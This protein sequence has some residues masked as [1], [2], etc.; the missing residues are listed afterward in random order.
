[1]SNQY[2]AGQQQAVAFCFVQICQGFERVA[3]GDGKADGFG[4]AQGG[5]V[6]ERADVFGD[7]FAE[8]AHIGAF[9]ATHADHGFGCVKFGNI[10]GVT[11]IS[12]GLRSMTMPLRAYSYSGLPSCMSAENIGGTWRM[13]PISAW[14]AV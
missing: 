13:L 1:M 8:G 5:Q 4:A 9:A 3:L 6:G 10:D 12:R 11:V 7:V 14:Q 2:V